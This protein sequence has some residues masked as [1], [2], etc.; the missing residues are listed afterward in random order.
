[1]EQR[2]GEPAESTN[3]VPLSY[4]SP[5][6]LQPVARFAVASLLMAGVTIAW[7]VPPYLC[8]RGWLHWGPFAD[9]R[10]GPLGE[11]LAATAALP[12]AITIVFGIIGLVLPGRRRRWLGAVAI[13]AVG[14]GYH[15]LMP[16]VWR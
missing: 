10:G 9:V 12:A 5:H 4:A 1:M 3:P 2:S 7:L 6:D 14:I 8:W 11:A 15:T 13:A 16:G